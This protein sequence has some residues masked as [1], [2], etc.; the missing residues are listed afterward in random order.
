M[1][2]GAL[3]GGAHSIPDCS[4]LASGDQV[5]YIF[6]SPEA[7]IEF[8]R[9][10]RDLAL[11]FEAQLNLTKAQIAEALFAKNIFTKT[12]SAH[13][14][15]TIFELIKQSLQN[16]EDVLISGFG[17]FSVKEKYESNGGNPQP[18]EPMMPAP[19]KVVTFK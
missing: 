6:P 15:E 17:K 1:L 4:A 16:G 12:Q 5:L 14:I 2:L 19:G 18:G 3:H 7:P 8:A 13:I 11:I 9:I 10:H